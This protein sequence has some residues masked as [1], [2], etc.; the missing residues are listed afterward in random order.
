MAESAISV[1]EGLLRELV[2][3]AES[4]T[5]GRCPYKNRNDRCTALFGCRNQQRSPEDGTS[6][7][8]CIGSDLLDYRLAW[9]VE[10]P[11][12]DARRGF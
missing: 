5:Q 12:G 6:G 7:P 1:A 11:S 2:L 8:L 3:K 9:Q 4:S 10:E